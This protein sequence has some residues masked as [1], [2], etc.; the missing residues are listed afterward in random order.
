MQICENIDSCCLVIKEKE[1]HERKIMCVQRK[2]FFLNNN[3]LTQKTIYFKGEC[4]ICDDKKNFDSCVIKQ[5]EE[6]VT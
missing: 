1:I 6:I 2:S 4:I 3:E 5:T